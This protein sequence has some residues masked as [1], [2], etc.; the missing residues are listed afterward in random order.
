MKF[1]VFVI[2]TSSITACVPAPEVGNQESFISSQFHSYQNDRKWRRNQLEKS[3]WKPE[4]PYAKKRL[5]AYALQDQGWDFLP[6]LN[7]Q[8]SGVPIT[9]PTSLP[10]VAPKDQEEWIQLGERVFWEMP[11]R[12]DPYLEWLVERPELWER[13]G[14]ERNEKGNLRGVAQFKDARGD[15]RVGAT[16][17]FCHGENGEA[18]RASRQLNLG[19]GRDLFN[20]ERGVESHYKNWGIGKVDV[21][22]DGVADAL[23]IPDLFT[24]A[25]KKHINSSASIKVHSPATLAI[26]FETQY[27]VGHSMEARPNRMYTWALAAFILSLSDTNTFETEINVPTTF[28]QKCSSCHPTESHFGG[29][30]VAH[31]QLTTDPNSAKSIKRGTGFY[32]SPLLKNVSQNAPYMH[33]GS[34]DTLEEILKEGHVAG[35]KLTIEEQSTLL[36]FLRRI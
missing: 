19:L 5:D 15:T 33:D 24:I 13:V 34:F 21:T 28:E 22:D 31:E 3:L 16:C 10:Q 36:N 14:L 35:Q 1:L 4:L 6:L 23:R 11:M 20:A 9:N 30:L 2:L 32:R 12:R 18:G 25:A 29:V 17:G 26:R 8:I 27:I 7:A